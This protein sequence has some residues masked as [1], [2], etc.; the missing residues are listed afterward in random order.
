M[1]PLCGLALLAGGLHLAGATGLSVAAGGFDLQVHGVAFNLARVLRGDVI[2]VSFHG[3]AKGDFVVLDLA[4]LDFNFAGVVSA[5]HQGAGDFV[6][7][8]FQLERGFYFCAAVT[9]GLRPS[10]GAGH[11]CLISGLNECA[12][13]QH[14]N[15]R[16]E[17]SDPYFRNSFHVNLRRKG[18]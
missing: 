15:Q 1:L 16:R 3:G 7:V 11:H 5:A 2:A 12:Q 8:L 14:E 18:D 17:P 9:A 6:A 4:I 10:P 13:T